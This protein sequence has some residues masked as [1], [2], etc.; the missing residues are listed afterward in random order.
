MIDGT[1]E[2]TR[3][4]LDGRVAVVT[5]GTGGIGSRL[6]TA[7][8]RVGA[9]VVVHGRDR[10]RAD[11][12]ARRLAAEGGTAIAATGDVTRREE[13]DRVV[14]EALTNYGRVDVIVTTVGGGA[15]SALYP[16]EDYP[17]DVWN[18]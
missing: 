17:D 3:F 1:D 18:R 6:C 8:A 14:D 9:Y 2:L 5:G 15:G 7:L 13:A 10:L 4:R 11:A 12:L 16:A